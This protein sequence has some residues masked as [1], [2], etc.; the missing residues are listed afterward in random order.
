MDKIQ[1]I[2]PFL[3]FDHQAEEAV[4]FYV[5]IFR[6]AKIIRIVRYGEAGRE[7]HRKPPGSVMTIAFELEG[8]PFTA[9]NGGPRFTFSQA[10]S[11]VI[12]CRTQEEIDHYW[13][14]LAEGGDESAQQC[15]WLKDKFGVSWQ[16]VPSN[17]PE[18]LQSPDPEKSRRVMKALLQ[19]KKL[20]INE[21]QGA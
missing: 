20:N 7:I 12:A 1:K 3:W 11:F 17:L 5:G 4:H 2:S 21:L 8:Q 10:I 19:M 9:L 16:I 14:K 13:D 15:G 18:L 6:D